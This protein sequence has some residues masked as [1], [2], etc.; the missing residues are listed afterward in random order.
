MRRGHAAADRHG[1]RAGRARRARARRA[2]AVGRHA[3][4]APERLGSASGIV[5]V[6]GFV[7]SLATI[8][9]IGLLLD[10]R[11]PDGPGDYTLDDFRVAFAAQYVVWAIGVAGLLTSRRRLRA[12]RAPDLDPF[13]RA[14]VRVARSRRERRRG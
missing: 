8:L 6:G 9:L 12:L 11:R 10:V 4:N 13:P 7:A 2:G 1:G 3:G 5:N 14:V